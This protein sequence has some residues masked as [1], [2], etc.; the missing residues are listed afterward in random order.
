VIMPS[1]HSQTR[2]GVSSADSLRE[3]QRQVIAIHYD[4]S[5]GMAGDLELQHRTLDRLM[6]LVE[7]I[8][9]VIDRADMA[10]PAQR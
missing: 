1:E 2:R 6:A 7:Q 4:L 10:T 8:E 9:G 5:E 3:I